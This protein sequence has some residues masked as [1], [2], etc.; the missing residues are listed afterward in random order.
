MCTEHQK[1]H[2]K[3]ERKV[4]ALKKYEDYLESVIRSNQDQYQNIS[5]LISRYKN[6]NRANEN[7]VRDQKNMEE[8]LERLKIECANFEKDKNHEIL[9]LNNEIKELQKNLEVIFFFELPS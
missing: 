1:T 4:A 2:A 3:L 8:E 9:Q 6:L 5:D 7:L